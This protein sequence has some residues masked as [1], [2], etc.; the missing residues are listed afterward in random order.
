MNRT[1]LLAINFRYF[2][3]IVG[4]NILFYYP[5]DRNF[6]T[7]ETEKTPIEVRRIYLNPNW[8]GQ[9][10]INRGG[11][12]GQPRS[13]SDG[14]LLAT[15]DDPTQVWNGLKIDGIPIGDILDQSF[16]IEMD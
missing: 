15:F 13:C 8:D 3:E 5:K 16:I 11:L 6:Y 4:L 14:E 10:E 9:H 7:I 12:D 1:K 2:V